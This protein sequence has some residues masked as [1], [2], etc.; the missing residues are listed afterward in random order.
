L[1]YFEKNRRKQSSVARYTVIH[2][3]ESTMLEQTLVIEKELGGNF[4]AS[5]QFDDMPSFEN[6]KEAAL[7][8]AD[9]MKRMSEAIENHWQD[10]TQHTEAASFA[11]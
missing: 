11:E 1:I 5:I 3:T 4:K 6:E 8:L 7:K 9:W 10:K 2:H